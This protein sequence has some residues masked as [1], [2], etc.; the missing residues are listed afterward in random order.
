MVPGTQISRRLGKHNQIDIK[1]SG[2]LEQ[3]VEIDIFAEINKLE[4]TLKN[5][6]KNT[7]PIK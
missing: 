5:Q 7:S 1:H 6:N 2:Q 4:Q 3:K